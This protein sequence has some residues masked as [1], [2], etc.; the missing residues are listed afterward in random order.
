MAISSWQ[1]ELRETSTDPADLL[2]RLGLSEASAYRPN[3]A[4][5]ALKSFPMR[6]PPDYLKSMQ[7]GDPRDPLFLQVFPAIWE[8]AAQAGFVTD[9]VGDLPARTAPGVLHKY[10]GRVLMLVTGA[11]AIHCRYCFRRHF[12]YSEANPARSNW[13]EALAYI[14]NEPS[15]REVILSG[16]DPLILSD[17]KLAELIASL[18]DIPHLRRLRIHSRIPVVLPSRLTTTMIAT[19]ATTKL[20]PVLV[21]HANHPNELSASVGAGLQ[22]LQAAGITLLNQSVLLKDI[23]DDASTLAR[24]NEALLACGALPYYLHMLDRVQGAAH[25]AVPDE[26]AR[27]IM[28]D[29]RTTLPGYLVPRLVR[30]IPGQA[31]KVPLL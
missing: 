17:D 9:P 30:E 14:A 15:I 23:N 29:L 25:F 24:L 6:V 16:G 11:C 4:H 7:A 18:E 19:L 27:R 5:E 21:I 8:D 10:H 20:I 12:P 22:A 28:Q 1:R 26:T 13:Q 2:K 3:V 31:Y